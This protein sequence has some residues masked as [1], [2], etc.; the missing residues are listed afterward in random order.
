L[1]VSFSLDFSMK[2]APL[3]LAAVVSASGLVDLLVAL[4]GVGRVHLD[5]GTGVLEGE[6]ACL[7]AVLEDAYLVLGVARVGDSLNTRALVGVVAR[8]GDGERLVHVPALGLLLEGL[9]HLAAAEEAVEL[10]I[11]VTIEEAVKAIA[12]VV[13]V[14]PPVVVV[15]LAVFVVV[16]VVFPPVVVVPTLASHSGEGQRGHHYGYHRRQ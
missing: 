10:A 2:S 4:G 9:V 16:V 8:V 1:R 7:G 5:G 11:E 13:V 3:P 14:F 15:P 12:V 6:V